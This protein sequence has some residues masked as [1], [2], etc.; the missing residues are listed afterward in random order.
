MFKVHTPH[1]HCTI[2][3]ESHKGPPKFM[4]RA[5]RLPLDEEELSFWKKL[6]SEMWLKPFLNIFCGIIYHRIINFTSLSNRFR[7]FKKKKKELRAPF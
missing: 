2:L 3:V 4:G 7:A 6:R 5:H 1:F